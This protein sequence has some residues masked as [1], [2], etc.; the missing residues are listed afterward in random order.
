MYRNELDL[1][2]VEGAQAAA[3][4]RT[5]TAESDNSPAQVFWEMGLV[6]GSALGLAAVIDIAFRVAG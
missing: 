2:H 1:L 6:L 4:P 3:P 5:A